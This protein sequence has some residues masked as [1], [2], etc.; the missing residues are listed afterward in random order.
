MRSHNQR[1]TDR[2]PPGLCSVCPV[3]N[4]MLFFVSFRSLY[5]A[6]LLFVRLSCYVKLS[7]W[8]LIKLILR[9][10]FSFGV[11]QRRTVQDP[12]QPSN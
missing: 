2:P 12:G 11:H 8:V 5:L 4:V 6:R 1:Q 10:H 9:E 3:Q 7:F